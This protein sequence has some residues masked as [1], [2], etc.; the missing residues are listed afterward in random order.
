M[1]EPLCLEKFNNTSDYVV[2]SDGRIKATQKIKEGYEINYCFKCELESGYIY[3]YDNL[4]IIA[5]PLNCSDALFPK[6]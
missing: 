1:M 2:E 6:G 4:K 3:T 5:K